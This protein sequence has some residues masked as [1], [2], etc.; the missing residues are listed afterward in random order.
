MKLARDKLAESILM[1]FRRKWDTKAIAGLW[2]M[3]ES[4]VANILARSRDAD[5]QRRIAA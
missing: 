1:L 4:E 2:V 5:Q 3:R